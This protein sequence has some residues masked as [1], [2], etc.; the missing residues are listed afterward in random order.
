M[1]LPDSENGRLFSMRARAC[2][3]F[4]SQPCPAPYR[5][6]PYFTRA[7]IANGTIGIGDRIYRRNRTIG[8]RSR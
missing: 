8:V 3:C 5:S 2:G 6:T 7:F 4:E 1:H